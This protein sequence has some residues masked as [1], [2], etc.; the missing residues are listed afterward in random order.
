MKAL[1]LFTLSFIMLAKAGAQ[2]LADV[3]KYL[4]NPK[5]YEPARQLYNEERK[6]AADSVTARVADSMLTRNSVTRP[7]YLLVV[8]RMFIYADAGLATMLYSRCDKV[9]EKYPNELVEFLYCNNNMVHSDFKN[10]WA[11]AIVGYIGKTHRDD[12]QAWFGK[13]REQLMKTCKKN[14]RTDLTAF[15]DTIAS[16]LQ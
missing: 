1:L 3:A 11:S 12:A 14:N 16:G 10:Y 9:L 5:I 13:L 6:A 15:L 8:S 2:P 7:F 4:Q